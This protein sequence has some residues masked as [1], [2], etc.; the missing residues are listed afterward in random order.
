[1]M[2][3]AIQI[4]RELSEIKAKQAAADEQHKTIF[5][6]LDKQDK[7]IECVQ[8]LVCSVDRLTTKLAG[9]QDKV[10]DMCNDLDEIKSKPAKRAE[11]VAMDVVKIVVAALVGFLLSRLGMG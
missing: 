1:M 4:E 6:R 8:G 3:Q 2:E 9:M 10:D 11:T 7:M 5:N